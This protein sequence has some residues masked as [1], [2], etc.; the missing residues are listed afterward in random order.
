VICIVLLTIAWI[1]SPD[2]IESFQN[3]VRNKIL[4]LLVSFYILHIISLL[5]SSNLSYAFF[6]L[7][8]KLGFLLF[9]LIL[10]AFSFSSDEIKRFKVAFIGGVFF[11]SVVC[12]FYA[13]QSYYKEADV[14]SFFYESYSHFLH[15]G[16]FTIYLSF[17]ILLVADSMFNQPHFNKR[18]RWAELFLMIFLLGNISL[19]TSRTAW[20][21]SVIM[22]LIY[23]FILIYQKRIMNTQWVFIIAIVL[24]IVLL[25]LIPLNFYNRFTQVE[26]TVNSIVKPVTP[27]ENSVIPVESNDESSSSVHLTLWKNAIKLICQ[28]PLFG[29]GI[30]DIHDE[31]NKEYS[32]NNFQFGIGKNFNPHNQYLHTGV[33]LGVIGILV[34]LLMLV[35]PFVYSMKHQEWIYALFILIIFLNSMTESILERQAGILF[36][37][38]FNSLFAVYLFSKEESVKGLI[39]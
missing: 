27:Q 23:F 31:L 8:V 15:P 16:Y 13:F 25:Q 18:C 11:A 22:L 26:E 38:F 39:P 7:Q 19:L 33:S 5:Y 1:V 34:L 4:L 3:V 24:S 30:G 9:P 37:S 12:L 2:F 32:K 6:D 20:I 10:S 29:V 14:D 36:F 35:F 28:H 21:T 17:A